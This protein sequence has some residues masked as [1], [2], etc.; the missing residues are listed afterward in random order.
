MAQGTPLAIIEGTW[1]TQLQSEITIAACDQGYC[2]RIS[3]IVVPQKYIDQYGDQ[4]KDISVDEYFD[5]NN[6]DPALRNRP[7]LNLQI[8][9]LRPTGNPWRFDGEIYNPEDGEIYSG[10]VEVVGAD[11][12]KLNGCVLYGLV[13]RGEEWQRVMNPE[14]AEQP[15]AAAVAPVPA[16]RAAT[17]G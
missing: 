14:A 13:C 8:L 16:T 7:V 11:I 5:Y 9:T 1:A 6:K 17:P 15:A 2:G 12:I 10:Y 4:L 3:K